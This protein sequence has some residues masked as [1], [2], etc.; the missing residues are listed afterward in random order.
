MDVNVD[1]ITTTLTELATTWGL[2]VVGV[3]VVLFIA[4]ILAGWSRRALQGAFEKRKFD[5]TLT[6]FFS[7][8]LRYAILVGAGLGCL[9]VF[10]IQTAS[11]AAVIAA[12]GLAIGL[13]FQGSLSNFA[14][15]V[16]LLVFRPFKVGDL[17]NVAGTLGIVEELEL[18]TT[19]LKSLDNRR[20]IVPNSSIF[21]STI[22]NVTHYD[23][24]RVDV[25]VGVEYRADIDKT[26]EVLESVPA[27]VE[28]ALSDP[29]PQ[30]F[31]KELGAS[32]VDWQVRVWCKTPDYWGVHQATVR[33]A[34][35][36][37]DAAGLGIPFPQVDVHFDAPVV[38][39]IG[40]AS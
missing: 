29:P 38:A 27:K 25:P 23:T 24:R 19:E 11:F 18:F 5:Q 35:Q 17:I 3:L 30:I 34:K 20:Y 32:S 2:R 10:G 40:K 36:A 26:R 15:G 31:L 1:K 28:G 4:W 9:G 21:G 39:A 22:E 33:A 12:G 6:R 37:L 16:M 13:A 8:M 7:N 14:A